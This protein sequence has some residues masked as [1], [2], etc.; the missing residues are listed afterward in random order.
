VPT[1]TLT[2]I[3][4]RAYILG[5]RLQLVFHP[6]I[7]R[8]VSFSAFRGFNP[9]GK[10]QGGFMN[11]LAMG[12]LG[13]AAIGLT[14]GTADGQTQKYA[15]KSITFVTFDG[16]QIGEPLRRH[17]PEFEKETGAKVN[18]VLTTFG[19]LF[20]RMFTDFTSGTNS[21]DGGVFDPQW[22]G[23]FALGNYLEP[24]DSYIAKSP[25]LKWNEVAP[26][27]REFSAQYAG[28]TYTIP[29]DGD[30][31]MV[32][33]RR[34]LW[35]NKA[36]KTAFKGKYNYDLRAPRTWKEYR[37]M[38]EFFNGMDVGGKKISGA[39]EAQ[40][41]N[42]QSFWLLASRAAAYMQY[43]G[44]AQGIFFDVNNMNPLIN[45]EGFVRALTE[46]KDMQ[47][48][49][50]PNILNFGTGEVRGG[51]TKSCDA[52]LAI[53]WGD[54]GSLSGDKDSCVKGK[55]GSTILPGSNEIW[56][57]DA[58]KWVTKASVNYAPYAAFGGWSG[59]VNAKSKNKEV[60]FD[61]LAFLSKPENS[62][63]DV[64]NGGTGF[65]PYRSSHFASSA[66]YVKGG[67]DKTDADLYL[68]A[69]KASLA[70]KN[71]VLDYRLPGTAR[72]QAAMDV[73][74]SEALSGQ[75]P[76]KEALDG[77][78]AEWDKI[79]NELGRAKQLNIYRASLKLKSLQ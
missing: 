48:F 24:L 74:V 76:P 36:N 66:L 13:L 35:A 6:E 20:P 58:K 22:L 12:A 40:Q 17:A 16:P 73:G 38:A 79:S 32:Y 28:K 39:I 27:F 9:L 75:K 3:Q 37:D 59:A 21:F 7:Y 14:L 1:L 72:Y 23:D 77:I 52:A 25:E 68:K 30:F 67:M 64:T 78:A 57:R 5:N 69:I 56:D 70:N 34:D 8:A 11:K 46:W 65:N 51:F 41:R 60:A 71:L 2:S 4:T 53:D 54:I 43:K 61:Y 63:A 55:L 10:F 31:Q 49:M 44:T 42:Q 26:F 33:Y 47:K 19:D 62:D 45:S 29:L 18:I 15:G 50:S